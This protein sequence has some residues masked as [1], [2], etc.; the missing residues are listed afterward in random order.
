MKISDTLSAQ[1]KDMQFGDSVG[2]YL[3]GVTVYDDAHVGH[4]RTI[5][6]FDV[7]RR[8]LES[9]GHAVR[10]VQNFTDVDDKIIQRARSDGV[11]AS[12]V[13]ERYILDYYRDFDR[14]HVKRAD[15]Y[16]KATSH[17]PE[18]L[19]LI[20]GL[21]SKGMAY[22]SKNGIYFSVPKFAGYGKLSKKDMGELRVGAR[23]EVDESKRDPLDFALWK[24]ADDQPKWGS[25]WGDGRPGWH[26]ECSA[27][28]LKYLGSGFDIHGGGRDLV[29]PH[30]ENEIAQS[31]GLTGTPFA[32]VWMHVGMV[33]ING[34]K[35]SKSLGNVK[36]VKH[37]LDHWGPN[38]MR[39]FCL[40]G[41]YSKPMDYSKAL[42]KESLVRWRQIE[43]AYYELFHA[44]GSPE[45]PVRIPE[46][47][48]GCRDEF[49]AGLEDDFNTHLALSAFFRLVR[50]VNVLAAEGRLTPEMSAAIRPEI[51]YCMEV[52]GL[53]M[54]HMADGEVSRVNGMVEE[55][56]RLR[57]S[58]RYKEADHIREQLSEMDIEILDHK[59]KTSWVRR[60]RIKADS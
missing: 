16:P 50:E 45:E 20:D 49:V 25:K 13:A 33:T 41:H 35:M 21:M 40:S 44:S 10:M 60:E 29:F 38:A 53:V 37:V 23:V 30:H 2:I 22:A 27:M 56:T 42:I 34:D 12:E 3:C 51:D 52:L 7:L 54:P 17:I 32:Q 19:E 43:T 48:R 9:A 1:E 46:I 36:T 8:Y 47:V 11:P 14:L 26:L 55:R 4:M 18:M 59:S 6:V 24:F 15:E 39:L 28:S 5:V 58:G 31:E 57:R